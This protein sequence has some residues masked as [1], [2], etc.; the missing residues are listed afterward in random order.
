VADFVLVHGA[1][2]GAWC[3]SRVLE[4]LWA[5]GRRVF[6]MSLSGVGGRAHL[7]SK[8]IT[9]NTHVADVA[10]MIEAEELLD[11]VLVGH[12]EGGIVITGVAGSPPLRGMRGG[13]T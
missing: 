10:R 6:A 4:P 5:A 8:G 3:W 9:L 7:L 2:Y 13:Q 11:A 1:W 12:G